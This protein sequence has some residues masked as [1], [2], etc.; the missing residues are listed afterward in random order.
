MVFE[1]RS[2]LYSRVNWGIIKILEE[3]FCKIWIDVRD[4]KPKTCRVQGHRSSSVRGRPGPP[5]IHFLNFCEVPNAKLIISQKLRI[6][7]KNLRLPKSLSEHSA[8]FFCIFVAEWNN[9]KEIKYVF[10]MECNNLDK[11]I[12]DNFFGGGVGY[13]LR[14]STRKKPNFI[15]IPN[16][17]FYITCTILVL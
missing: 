13:L 15:I 5:P 6:A 7:K 8:F 12:T 14:M 16:N 4:I 17:C 3:I 2:I 9:S 10:Q 1:I 11:K